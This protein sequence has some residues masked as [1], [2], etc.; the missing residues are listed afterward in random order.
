MVKNLVFGEDVFGLGDERR[1]C[2]AT[3]MPDWYSQ[4]NYSEYTR[5]H[6]TVSGHLPVSQYRTPSPEATYY[7]SYIILPYFDLRSYSIP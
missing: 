1:I 4:M 6:T 3:D 5:G 7:L 2:Q